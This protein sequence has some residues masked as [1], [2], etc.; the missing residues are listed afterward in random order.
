MRGVGAG[1][2]VNALADDGL[3][4]KQLGLA[5]LGGTEL[6]EGGLD[7]LN[8]VAVDGHN[9]PAVRLIA[10]GSVL[11]LGVLGHLVEGHVV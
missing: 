5:V 10:H 11:G 8:V 7:G 6:V 9:L 1:D 2:L 4:D 3:G